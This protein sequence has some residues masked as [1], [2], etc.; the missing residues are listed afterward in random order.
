[1]WKQ[2]G[3]LMGAV[4]MGDPT[5]ALD[6]LSEAPDVEPPKPRAEGDPPCGAVDG[7]LRCS[8]HGAGGVCVMAETH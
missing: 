1:M 2:L 7:K 8:G 6:V 4:V 3:R 5:A